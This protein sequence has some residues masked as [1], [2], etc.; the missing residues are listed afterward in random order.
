VKL[1]RDEVRAA[2][3]AED[4]AEH[5][6][7]KGRWSGRW[8]HARRCAETDHNSDAFAL[9]RDGMWHC[10]SCDK[11]GDLLAL[12]ALG[13]R[14]NIR[15]DFG[16]VLEIAAG[17]AGIETQSGADMFGLGPLKPDRPARPEPPPLP[18]IRDRI[19][20]AKKRAAWAWD[21]LWQDDRTVAAY[22]RSRGLEPQLVL[23]RE[24]I[25]MSPLRL[26][27]ELRRDIEARAEH[28]SQDISTLWYTMGTRRGTVSMVV[29]VRAAAGGA[30]VD[31]RARRFDPEPG[32]PKVIGMVGGV[33]S[34]P[35]ERGRAR[36]LVGCYGH[37]E[38][39]D[40]DLVVVVEGLMDYLTALQ[41]WPHS[42]VL[43]AVE[44]G[45]IDL[46]AGWAAN[47][48]A[49]RD[50]ESRL[51]I[52]QQ[53]DPQRTLRDG[54]VVPGAADAAINDKPNAAA[55][56][57]QLLLT[58]RRVGWLL[59]ESDRMLPDGRGVVKDLNDLVVVGADVAG[60]CTWLTASG[61]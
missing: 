2:L 55:K 34:A 36:S 31:L 18:P 22:L 52:V 41:L 33:T 12:I 11:G 27:P 32:Q 23:A 24:E 26:D 10:H 17:I 30:M 21:R 39:V 16:K 48:L 20:A 8:M 15:D 54:S 35:A 51:L 6:G 56:V 19:A 29:P 58:P 60:M 59:C 47:A 38:S 46:V 4:V 25:R 61:A 40:A 9:A 13:E 43:G 1:D 50:S 3:R 5:L 42:Q 49:W 28:V 7:I 45:S 44:A 57:S 53:A 14:L 37:P